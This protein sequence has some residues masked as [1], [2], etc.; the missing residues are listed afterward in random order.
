LDKI[1]ATKE[2]SEYLKL[3]EITICILEEKVKEMKS[4]DL[5]G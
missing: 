5:F 3:H 2:M 1:M 4:I